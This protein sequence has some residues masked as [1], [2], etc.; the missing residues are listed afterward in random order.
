MDTKLKAREAN[1]QKRFVAQVN[2][3][4]NFGLAEQTASLLGDDLTG[5]GRRG[6]ARPGWE[7]LVAGMTIVE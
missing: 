7:R 5:P 4:E 3:S 2:P 1:P 6:C